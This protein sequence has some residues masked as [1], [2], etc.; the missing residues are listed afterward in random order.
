MV[1]NSISFP[2]QNFWTIKYQLFIILEVT[3]LQKVGMHNFRQLI[4][5]NWVALHKWTLV[6]D[7]ENICYSKYLK[8]STDIIDMSE[9]TFETIV[10]RDKIYKSM[11]KGNWLVFNFEY[12]PVNFE[13]LF[14]DKII[15]PQILDPKIVFNQLEG[16]N[17]FVDEKVDIS[18]NFRLIILSKSTQWD[19]NIWYKFK[20]ISIDPLKYKAEQEEKLIMKRSGNK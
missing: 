5:K 1:S 12:L 3:E 4:N 20:H 8:Y 13:E 9:L 10:I 14:K 15:Y 7:F 2:N 18:P 16:Y 11:R 19:E 6:K 17:I